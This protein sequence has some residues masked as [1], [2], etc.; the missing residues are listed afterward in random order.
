MDW[1]WYM[2]RSRPS[3]NQL[4]LI[5]VQNCCWNS[6]LPLW[7]WE[8]EKGHLELRNSMNTIYVLFIEDKQD[9]KLKTRKCDTWLVFCLRTRS[10]SSLSKLI[11]DSDILYLGCN[12]SLRGSKPAAWWSPARLGKAAHSSSCC[13]MSPHPLVY[14]SSCI[15]ASQKQRYEGKALGP[16]RETPRPGQGWCADYLA[17]IVS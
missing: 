13:L 4:I 17:A 6:N 3:L 7:N 15:Q 12:T 16:K 8:A 2:G 9:V 14:L 11:L 1:K 5:S 10:T